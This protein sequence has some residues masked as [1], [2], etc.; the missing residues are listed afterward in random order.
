MTQAETASRSPEPLYETLHHFD[1]FDDELLK[2][3]RNVRLAPGASVRW[4][5]GQSNA[6]HAVPIEFDKVV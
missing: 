1:I 3:V 6:L 4:V 2:R 5:A